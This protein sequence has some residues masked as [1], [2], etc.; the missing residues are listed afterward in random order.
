MI[1]GIGT[2]LASIPRARRAFERTG[3][4][5]MMRRVLTESERSYCLRK[6]DP[7]PS[8]S[9]RFAAKEAVMKLLGT[10]LGRGVSWQHIEVVRAPSGAPS[11]ALHARAREIAEAKGITRILLSLTHDGEYALAFAVGEGD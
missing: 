6:A 11:I 5:R 9:A 8:F 10:G 3:A 1:I 2:D 4:E 7:V